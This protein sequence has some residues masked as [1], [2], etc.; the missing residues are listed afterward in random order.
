[1][2]NCGSMTP[3]RSLGPSVLHL[4]TPRRTEATNASGFVVW[5]TGPISCRAASR[6]PKP[7]IALS[8]FTISRATLA[9]RLR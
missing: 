9:H 1:V 8:A 2:T 6:R 7:M 4:W 3:R 5:R